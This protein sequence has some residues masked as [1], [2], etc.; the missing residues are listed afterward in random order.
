MSTHISKE[1][2]LCLFRV[3]QEALHNAVKY[4]GVNQFTV[5]LIGKEDE[6]QLIE[7]DAGVGFDVEKTTV[8]RGLGLLS[9]QERIH[10][11][12]GSFS[13]NSK[14]GQ[15]TTILAAVPFVPENRR[16]QHRMQPQI[17]A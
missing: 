11:V 16:T 7:N 3:A 14:P 10:L 17:I 1:I 8:N 6:I 5:G 2:S 12:R 9:M 4:S 15:G 13:V